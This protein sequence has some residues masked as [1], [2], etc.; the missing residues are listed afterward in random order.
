[1]TPNDN[2]TDEFEPLTLV[3]L[4]GGQ[5]VLEE[6]EG[7]ST[8]IVWASDDDED[9]SEQFPDGFLTETDKE[10]VLNYLVD[11]DL[12]DEADLPD[13]LIE[14]ESYTTEDLKELQ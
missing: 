7:E 9:F 5:A 14:V 4:V 6:G 2:E 13:I 12:I 11:E 8:E 10:A 3:F 1:M